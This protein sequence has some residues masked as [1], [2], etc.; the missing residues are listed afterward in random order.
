[1][2]SLATS[3]TD[4]TQGAVFTG[5]GLREAREGA[6]LGQRGLALL[7]GVSERCIRRWEAHEEDAIAWRSA[8]ALSMAVRCVIRRHVEGRAKA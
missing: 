4:D 8:K 2:A 6:D 1:M 5:R 7:L 3:R